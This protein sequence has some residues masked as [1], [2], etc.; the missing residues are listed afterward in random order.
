MP[1]ALLPMVVPVVCTAALV[2]ATAVATGIGVDVAVDVA[3]V[4][5]VE[6]NVLVL[7]EANV[8]VVL[9]RVKVGGCVLVDEVV[10]AESVV[11]VDVCG[12]VVRVCVCVCVRVVA[13]VVVVAPAVVVVDL[14]TSMVRDAE[15][16]WS[17]NAPLQTARRRQHHSI[18]LSDQS[19]LQLAS[20]S[21]S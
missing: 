18:R 15:K 14:E 13:V 16:P 12:L 6:A 2:T 9:W 11:F 5:L 21:Q 4:V 1:G 3:A 7:V 17:A 10:V 8:V 20:L 19:S